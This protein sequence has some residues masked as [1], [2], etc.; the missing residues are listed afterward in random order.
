MPKSSLKKKIKRYLK[1]HVHTKTEVMPSKNNGI[2][3][4]DQVL[5]HYNKRTLLTAVITECLTGRNLNPGRPCSTVPIPA[6]LRWWRGVLRLM[7]GI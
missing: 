4:D 1:A 7:I 2:C 6:Y 3:R 5:L